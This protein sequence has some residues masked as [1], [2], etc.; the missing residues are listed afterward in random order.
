MPEVM[1]AVPFIESQALVQSEKEMT[2]VQLI[3]IDVDYEKDISPLA[4]AMVQGELSDLARQKYQIVISQGLA[5]RLGVAVGDSVRLSVLEGARYTPMGQMPSQRKFKVVGLF[6]MGSE[7]DL[8][9][10]YVH[11]PDAA[12]LIRQ[13]VDSAEGIRLYL[14]DAYLANAVVQQLQTN[15]LWQGWTIHSWQVSYGGLFAAVK[16]EK[17]MMWLLLLLIIAVAAF[18]I[19]SALFLIV[20]SKQSDVAI[21]QTLGLSPGQITQIFLVQGCAQGLLGALLGTVI[22]LVVTLNL[23]SL[24]K[25]SEIVV[26]ATPGYSNSSLPVDIQFGQV[27]WVFVLAVCM[28]FLATLYPARQAAAVMPAEALRY[29]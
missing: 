3:G 29:E 4:S 9:Y 7:A 19:V 21:L 15:G 25:F 18:N 17:G 1:G 24:L 23:N 5:F 10:V 2:G 14:T 13:P 12:R 20:A 16:M 6:N 8:S 26:V 11:A 27:A 28:S 22:G